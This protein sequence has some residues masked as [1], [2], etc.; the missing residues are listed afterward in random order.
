MNAFESLSQAGFAG[1]GPLGFGGGGA[2]PQPTTTNSRTP[3]NMAALAGNFD[4]APLPRPNYWSIDKLSA[5]VVLSP[6]FQRALVGIA[7]MNAL[8]K[9]H[10]FRPAGVQSGPRHGDFQGKTH[11][12]IGCRELLTGKPRVRIQLGL[13]RSE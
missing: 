11:L 13:D 2:C 8:E 6:A 5:V 12:H 10:R 3:E 9:R 4:I 1:A 7:R